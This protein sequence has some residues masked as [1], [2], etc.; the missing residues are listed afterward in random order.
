[1]EKWTDNVIRQ[2]IEELIEESY[3]RSLS[4]EELK[5]HLRGFIKACESVIRE[6]I[7]LRGDIRVTKIKV[8]LLRAYLLLTGTRDHV[9][10]SP[11]SDVRGSTDHLARQV[12]T[13]K[14][15]VLSLLGMIS[16]RLVS[17][18]LDRTKPADPEWIP[19]EGEA[20]IIP[21]R[22]FSRVLPVVGFYGFAAAVL[23]MVALAVFGS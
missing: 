9:P 2:H 13:I 15:S 20:E 10:A 18:V 8:A 3:L 14:R 23:L 21:E 22:R 17:D 7:T 1:M 5:R 12:L 16:P 4:E 6:N 11:D 19:E